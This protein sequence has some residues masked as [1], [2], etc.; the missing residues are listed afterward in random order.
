M[1]DEK[2]IREEVF[3]S[4]EEQLKIEIM[5]LD[6]ELERLEREKIRLMI[7]K[8]LS[9]DNEVSEGKSQTHKAHEDAGIEEIEKKQIRL[10]NE[11]DGKHM[12][13]TKLAKLKEKY[14]K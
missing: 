11:I 13:M 1:R 14:I 2:K 7:L 9:S 8:D 4:I 6:K 12:N 3:L 5:E 10:K